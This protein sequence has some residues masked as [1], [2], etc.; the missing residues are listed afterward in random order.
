MANI[1]EASLLIDRRYF[2]KT[3]L[4]CALLGLTNYDSPLVASRNI[5]TVRSLKNQI[6][7]RGEEITNQFIH[8]QAREGKLPGTLLFLLFYKNNPDFKKSGVDFLIA[9]NGLYSFCQIESNFIGDPNSTDKVRDEL[10]FNLASA[11][12]VGLDLL[13]T[14]DPQFK[15]RNSQLL[16]S[17]SVLRQDN[18]DKKK[19][20]LGLYSKK[21]G[22]LCDIVIGT[23]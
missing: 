6:L 13:H 3:A 23:P 2:L 4:S 18:F 10:R 19:R 17:M 20:G 14:L 8:V 22:E 7:H 11:A 12:Q 9:V 16:S 21:I 5:S 1:E 15:D